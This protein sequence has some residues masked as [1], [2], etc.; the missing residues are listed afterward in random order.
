MQQAVLRSFATV[1]A[2]PGQAELDQAAEPFA[3][4]AAKVRQRPS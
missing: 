4:L 2:P 3:V 1:G